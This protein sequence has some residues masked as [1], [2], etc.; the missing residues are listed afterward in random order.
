[1]REPA[2]VSTPLG[3]EDVL[4]PDGHTAAARFVASLAKH[5]KLTEAELLGF[6]K[7]RKYDETVAAL[8]ELSASSIDVIRPR[9]CRA[10][11]TTAC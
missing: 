11:A 1:M 8:A 7:E 5:G 9:R 6:A 10:C 3:E 2:V 4:Q